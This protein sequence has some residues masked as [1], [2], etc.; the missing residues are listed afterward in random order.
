LHYTQF[1]AGA[2]WIDE[3]GDPN[4]TDFQ[5]ALHRLS[6][7]VLFDS[8]NGKLPAI[9]MTADLTVDRVSPMHALKLYA[10]LTDKNANALLYLNESGGHDGNTS[11]KQTA[12]NTA[13]VIQFLQ[14]QFGL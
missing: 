2:S 9:L 3:Y 7:I 10:K 13:V 11:I 4:H 8:V 14:Q 1:G 6:R 12:K 5:A